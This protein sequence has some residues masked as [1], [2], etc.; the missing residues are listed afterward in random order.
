MSLDVYL[1]NG[2]P[3]NVQVLGCDGG[4]FNDADT[5]TANVH[6]RTTSSPKTKIGVFYTP[7]T[8]YTHF[9]GGVSIALLHG[10]KAEF[11]P[12][13]QGPNPGFYININDFKNGLGKHSTALN[14]ESVAYFDLKTPIE[15]STEAAP[16]N[17]LLNS[18]M[19][20]CTA[21]IDDTDGSIL[22]ECTQLTDFA[23]VNQIFI[24][25]R[26]NT[27]GNQLG[28][29]DNP[30][31]APYTLLRIS[32]LA[33]MFWYEFKGFE[34]ANSYLEVNTQNNTYLLKNVSTNELFILDNTGKYACTGNSINDRGV[35]IDQGFLINN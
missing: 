21:K 10:P 1:Q 15:E 28:Y 35:L 29:W 5:V 2:T 7:T 32:S 19:I 30:W 4:H 22:I 13:N 6:P 23:G 9:T 27:F 25:G 11:F 34:T 3:Y 24:T 17:S 18:M 31:L 14:V 12:W 8:I 16:S 33:G 20:G 26:P